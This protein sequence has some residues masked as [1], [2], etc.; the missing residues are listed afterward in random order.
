MFPTVPGLKGLLESAGP[1]SS[2]L[3]HYPA[4]SLL[5]IEGAH[6]F[7]SVLCWQGP[8]ASVTLVGCRSPENIYY[9]KST[10]GLTLVKKNLWATHSSVFHHSEYW[11]V[12]IFFFFLN[13]AVPVAYG[14]S[15]LGVELKLQLPAYTTAIATSDPSHVC[16]LHHSSRQCQILNPLSEAQDR[17]HV[18]TDASR[19]HS[20]LSHEGHS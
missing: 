4:Q 19:F 18:L 15:K 2:V 1:G 12:S 17:T 14:S 3:L 16:N 6:S 9:R 20:A 5:S 8:W 13:R 7:T 10:T 11:V